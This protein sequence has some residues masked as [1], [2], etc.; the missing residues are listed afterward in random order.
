MISISPASFEVARVKPEMREGTKNFWNF[1]VVGLIPV[2]VL[3]A[4]T[5]V[6]L[7]RRD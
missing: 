6:Y 4:G 1:I 3:A 7:N 2:L 5:V